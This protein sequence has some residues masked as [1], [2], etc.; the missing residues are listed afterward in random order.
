LR[1]PYFFC[2]SDVGF[3]RAPRAA[4]FTLIFPEASI[5][6]TR[7]HNFFLKK[8]VSMMFHQKS[9]SEKREDRV[10]LYLGHSA[11]SSSASEFPTPSTLTSLFFSLFFYTARPEVTH[12]FKRA[13]QPHWA[14]EL[15][16]DHP[17][18]FSTSSSCPF[19]QDHGKV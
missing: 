2:A 1:L 3:K 13:T 16:Q 18:A 19:N 9:E 8:G 14:T 6:E 12:F 7:E 17:L 15:Y 11:R 10:R 5:G 4:G